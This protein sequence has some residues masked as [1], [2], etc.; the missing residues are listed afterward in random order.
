MERIMERTAGTEGAAK[1]RLDWKPA[2]SELVESRR[3]A[4]Q[5]RASPVSWK[6]ARRLSS[7]GK[8]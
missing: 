4:F 6:V 7:P 2:L 3:A 8:Q 5:D 1:P